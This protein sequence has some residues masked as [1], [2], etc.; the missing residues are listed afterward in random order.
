V[1]EAQQQLSVL[2]GS[3][4]PQTARPSAVPLTCGRLYLLQLN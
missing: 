2:P 3:H 1:E 4:Q